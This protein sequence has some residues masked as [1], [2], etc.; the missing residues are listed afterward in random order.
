LRLLFIGKRFNTNRDA[1]R[2]KFG[3]NYQFPLHLA[4]QHDVNLWL[5]DYHSASTIRSTDGPLDI[6]STPVKNLAL[7]KHYIFQ[8]YKTAQPIDIV[9]ASGDCYIGLMAQRIAKKIK[10]KFVFDVYDKY[11]EFGGYIKPLG[12]DIFSHLL[13]TADMRMFAS[14]ALL[15]TL[16]K[17]ESDTILSNGIDANHFRPI[18]KM[19]ARKKIN[20]PA[21]KNL[22]GY[23]GSMEPDRGVQ[24]LIAAVQILRKQGQSV[25]LLL[26]GKSDSA[27]SL[28]QPGIIYL[29][30]IDFNNIPYA[31]AACDI[32][33]VPYRR[34]PFMDAGASNKIAEAMACHRPIVAT[35]SPN[36]ISNFPEQ[37]QEL[38][39]YLAEPGN[40]ISLAAAISKQLLDS[41]LVS[42]P[43]N[44]YWNDI[45]VNVQS[46]FKNLINE[47]T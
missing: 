24:D 38:D 13:K 31:L 23:F 8:K 17:P 16:G 11:D 9:I 33:A 12:F 46:Y 43:R 45:T 19:E 30:N 37:T 40:P 18:E 34:S 27:L 42:A 25:E 6:I 15:K 32:L 14:T 7:F 20:L 5:V 44:I 1:L 28:H 4:K 47:S 35:R 2:E 22:I 21:E 36:L 41:K 29:G 3:R 26:G 10:A 39:Q